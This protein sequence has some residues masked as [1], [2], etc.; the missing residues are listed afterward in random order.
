V[1]FIYERKSE[2]W[3]YFSPLLTALISSTK[4]AEMIPVG[5][6]TIPIPINEM[7]EAKILPPTV[8]G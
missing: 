7:I 4:E 1:K 3:N 5:I 6:A 8:T 2:E